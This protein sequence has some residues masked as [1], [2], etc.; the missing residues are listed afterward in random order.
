M[1]QDTLTHVLRQRSTEHPD[2]TAYTFLTDS[3]VA[4]PSLT[5]SQLDRRAR[6]VAATLQGHGLAGDR[7]LLLLPSSIEFVA[8]LFG[9]FFS[10]RIA[11]PVAV[12]T[13]H[14]PLVCGIARD[15]LP[16][17]VLT[18]RA[19]MET[20]RR[21]WANMPELASLHWIAVDQI[22]D[23]AESI[24]SERDHNQSSGED[25]A[26]LQYTSGSTAGPKG[27][28]VGHD[29]IQHNA[30]L[31][32]QRFGAGERS[33]YLAWSPLFHDFGLIGGIFQPLLANASAYLMSPGHFVQRP[34]RWLAAITRFGITI[35][36]GP[37]FAYDLCVDRISDPARAG[38]DLRSWRV[39]ANGAEVVRAST[40]ERFSK[41]FAPHGFERG[42][43]RPAYGL[44]ES[45]LVVTCKDN[46]RAPL[47]FVTDCNALQPRS[48]AA[49]RWSERGI[50]LVGCGPPLPGHKV[51]I[52]DP[53]SSIRCDRGRVGEIWVQ[54][55]SVTRGYW[56][57][58]SNDRGGFDARIAGED[59]NRFL[60]TGDLG[61]F[62]EDELFVAGRIKDLIVIDGRNLQAETIEATIERAHHEVV[63]NGC[64]AFSVD[65]DHGERLVLAVEIRRSSDRLAY[66]ELARAI[67]RTIAVHQS[68]G[69]HAVVFTGPRQLPRTTSGKLRRGACLQAFL[70]GTLRAEYLWKD[71]SEAAR[72]QPVQVMATASAVEAWLVGRLA[73]VLGTTRAAI[74]TRQPLDSLGLC[75]RHALELAGELGDWIGR[76]VSPTILIEAH[77]IDEVV[78][79][80][81]DGEPAPSLAATAELPA[82]VTP[83]DASALLVR[84]DEL[85]ATE[86]EEFLRLH[87]RREP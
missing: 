2:K 68:V 55:P 58:T 75:S 4:G 11:V 9:C 20:L 77:S 10:R 48:V 21:F 35:S 42:A 71:T 59:G 64:A 3:E 87:Q 80:V 86:V 33:I 23:E 45:T 13:R 6:A 25:I 34:R 83:E 49:A 85:S 46:D 69:V 24:W 44:A 29:N 40:I 79:A 1:R 57:R 26:L 66:D 52:V 56:G 31:G 16:C 39:A 84:L 78:A 19:T 62:H 53:E 15:C 63:S 36:G 51:A 38:L 47:S 65:V 72:T 27:I 37:N 73:E 67:R 30:R 22:E 8:A 12:G 17:A 28:M 61:F 82:D 76:P 5:Y 41:A 50:N 60:R 70:D 43:F 7:V 32:A 18:T 81:V 54:G 14:L 74:D